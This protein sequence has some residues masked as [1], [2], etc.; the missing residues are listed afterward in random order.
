MFTGIVLER[1]KVSRARRRGGLLELEIE[2]PAVAR[3]L[4][5]GDSVAVDGVCLTAVSTGRKRFTAEVMG[6]TLARTTLG[7]LGKGRSVNLELALRLSDRLGGHLIQ[8]HVDG[9]GK[10]M[11]IEDTDGMRRMWIGAGDDVLR[12]LAPKGSVAV[13]GVSLTIVDVGRASFE[14]A[15]IPHTLAIT[16]LG[17]T[18]V[19]DEVNLEVDVIARYVDRLSRND[20]VR[21]V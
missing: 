16:T 4:E 2:A 8:G 10:V 21:H 14:I 1:G 7:E 6:E 3:D 13:S 19:G 15:L 9:V 11:R 18:N 20:G 5:R 12:Y 17:G